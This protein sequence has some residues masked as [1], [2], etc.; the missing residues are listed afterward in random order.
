MGE[1]WVQNDIGYRPQMIQDWI[2]AKPQL[3]QISNAR[4]DIGPKKYREKWY[5]ARE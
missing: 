2:D 3:Y 5:R 1:G 4:N